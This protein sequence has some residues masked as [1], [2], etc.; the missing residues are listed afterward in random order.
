MT[1]T[2]SRWKG[3]YLDIAHFT[4]VGDSVTVECWSNSAPDQPLISTF[5]GNLTDYSATKMF[6][7]FLKTGHSEVNTDDIS[8]LHNKVLTEEVLINVNY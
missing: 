7:H 4:K 2:I 8:F 1:R 6:N 5:K 3:L